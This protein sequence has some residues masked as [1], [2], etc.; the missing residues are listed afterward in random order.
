M[1]PEQAKGK[2]VDPRVDVWAFGCVFYEMVTGWRPFAG[3]DVTDVVAA[4]MRDEPDWSGCRVDAKRCRR[5]PSD[6]CSAA[7]TRIRPSA[8][9]I[10]AT[11]VWP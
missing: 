3:E 1:A 4:I 5:L 6:T 10:W 7:S 9:R 11:S 2:P 8:C